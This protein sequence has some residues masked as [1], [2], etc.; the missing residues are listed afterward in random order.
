MKLH[1]ITRF[2]EHKTTSIR[3]SYPKGNTPA[4]TMKPA[5]SMSNAQDTTQT[6]LQTIQEQSQDSQRRIRKTNNENTNLEDRPQIE[7]VLSEQKSHTY[8]NSNPIL[9]TEQKLNEHNENVNLKNTGSVEE[10]YLQTQTRKISQTVL[11]TIKNLPKGTSTY[12]YNEYS[13]T[14]TEK[15]LTTSSH[16]LSRCSGSLDLAMIIVIVVTSVILTVALIAIIAYLI[17][18][19]KTFIPTVQ[20][21]QILITGYAWRKSVRYILRI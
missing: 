3:S 10:I 9:K 18:K 21:R 20:N 4:M 15:R 17:M 11:T 2:L 16:P 14:M 12:Q 19:K 7:D 1:A 5:F 6:I 13:T 8:T